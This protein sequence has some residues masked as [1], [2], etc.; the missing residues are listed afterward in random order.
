M[1]NRRDFLKNASLM[2]AGGLVA[3]QLLSSCA[4]KAAGS[5]KFI[6]L[7]L[8]SLREMVKEQ[9]IKAVM[10]SV[11]KMGYKNVE[12]AGYDDGKIYGLAPAE[13]KKICDDLGVKCTSAHLSQAFSK[14]KEAEI[15]A[16]WDKAIEAHNQLG[17]KYMVQPWM[18]VNNETTLDDLKMYCDYFT[19]VGYKTAAASIAFGYHNHDFE[20]KKIEDQLIYD[21]LLNNVSKNHVFFQ[22]DVYWCQVGGYDPA[23]YLKNYA[24][25][26]KTVH[27]KDEKEIG[28]SG[29]MN[30]Q[31]IFEQMKANNVKDWYVEVEQYTNNAPEA[32]VKESFDFLNNSAFVY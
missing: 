17:V 29:K 23:E 7:Q 24:S 4:G 30:F 3:P 25:Q 8:Y 6:G 28:A 13:F 20:F 32:S 14:E 26:I 15:M 19:S 22:L 2:L 10:E 5:E 31:P 18:P 11:A 1:Q 16:W 27:I 9:G 12:T 21:F